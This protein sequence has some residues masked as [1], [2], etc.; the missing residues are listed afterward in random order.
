MAE[1]SIVCP[2]RSMKIFFPFFFSFDICVPNTGHA[3]LE[4]FGIFF[5]D[6]D[7]RV[8]IDRMN[9]DRFFFLYPF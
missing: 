3:A 2:L 1:L 7:D 9:D 8:D 6:G 5:F 4:I